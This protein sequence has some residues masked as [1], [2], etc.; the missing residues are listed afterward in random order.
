M[1]IASVVSRP[2]LP[3]VL[4]ILEVSDLGGTRTYANQLIAY[5]QSRRWMV[6]VV[7]QGSSEAMS[8]FGSSL[9]DRFFQ[10]PATSDPWQ[11][12]P[13]TL[14]PFKLKSERPLLD[15]FIN[16][17][18]P[19]LIVASVGTP[20][21]FLGHLGRGR[22]SL[23]ILHTYP[24][25]RNR[26][27][28]YHLFR[29]AL[30][31]AR[32]PAGVNFLTVSE[33]SRRR[34]GLVW[35][36]SC[37][38][39]GVRVIHNTA[40]PSLPPMRRELTSKVILTV[41]HV[42]DYKNPKA[43]IDIARKVVAARP[44]VVFMWV[45]TGPLLEAC[46]AIVNDSGFSDRIKFV[47]G[48]KDV[49][50]YLSKASVYLHPSRVESLGIAVLEAMRWGLP[51]VVSDSGG[52]PELVEDGINGF[53]VPVDNVELFAQKTMFL[54]DSIEEARI[55]GASARRL[56]E[57]KFSQAVWEKKLDHLHE[58]LRFKPRTGPKIERG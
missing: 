38:M 42:I 34:L 5:Y 35:G 25:T 22:N 24:G 15:K 41:G 17:L 28:P 30:I 47:G 54:V 33:F 58:V 21:K 44:E 2:S 6:T 16:D 29:G 40:G 45:G 36:L 10:I 20:G 8:D 1:N 23:Y 14:V 12:R 3:S 49:G 57:T 27:L 11:T 55:L 51:V 37:P 52:L 32:I 43:W 13:A 39:N 48:R 46:R 9:G 4:L 50:P 18:G 26:N 31:R 19:D 7:A 53:V 56:Y